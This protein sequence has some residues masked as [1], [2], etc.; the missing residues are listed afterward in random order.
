[1][2]WDWLTENDLGMDIPHIAHWATLCD[3]WMQMHGL[4]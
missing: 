4:K 2:A 3:E 1:M